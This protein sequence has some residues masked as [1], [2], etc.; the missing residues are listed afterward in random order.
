MQPTR[1]L[2]VAALIWF[3]PARGD[4]CV[5]TKRDR[6]RT[7]M[8]EFRH[9][10][11]WE[12]VLTEDTLN[13]QINETE[14]DLSRQGFKEVHWHLSS[15][16]NEGYEIYELDLSFNNLEQLNELTFLKFYSLETLNLSNNRIESI[17]NLTFGSL[18]RLAELDLSFNL[19]HTLEKQAFDR[20]YGL[21]SLSL[22]ENCL[23]TLAPHQFYFNDHLSSLL[24][25]HNQ[26]SFLPR[27]LFDTITM[28]DELYELDLSNNNFRRMPYIDAKEISLLKIENNHIETLTVNKSFNVRVLQMQNNN[29]YD[30]DLF[31]FNRAEHIDLSHNNLDNIV[32]LHEM[33]QLEYLDLSSNNVSRFDYN[34]KYSIRNIPGLV[35]LRLQNCSLTDHNI[36]GLLASESILYLDLSQN[37]FV[38]LNVSHLSRLRTLQYLSLNFNYLRELVN[39]ERMGHEFPYLERVSLSFNRWNCSYY[40]RL[41][42]HLNRTH[43]RST[44]DPR[45]CYINGTHVTDSYVT[46]VFEPPYTM[47]QVKRDMAV[48]RNLGRHT[49]Y[50]LLA[51]FTSMRSQWNVSMGNQQTYRRQMGSLEHDVD[52]LFGM[53]VFLV[54]VFAVALFVGVAW[55]CQRLVRRWQ[56]DRSVKVVT[57][58]KRANEFSNGVTVNDVIRDNVSVA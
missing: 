55:G 7:I 36:E 40:D 23:V 41:N 53:V 31:A 38:R 27:V 44:S 46:D 3:A 35:T 28:V 15:I 51:M 26:L 13:L 18:I 54:A 8:E 17:N 48:L 2:F 19:I 47:V 39:Y 20:L 58:Q 37:N 33:T 42:A 34:L 1:F 57:Y 25:D 6:H 21:E 11:N 50:F 14:V 29:I 45:D 9:S 52:R 24:L 10:P 56:H 5:S 30:A 12:G 4:E 43:I 16:V 49:L 22:R 32:G